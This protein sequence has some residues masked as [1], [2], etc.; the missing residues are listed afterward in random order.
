MRLSGDDAELSVGAALK[1]GHSADLATILNGNSGRPS[2]APHPPTPGLAGCRSCSPAVQ[3][4]FC[5]SRLESAPGGSS[6]P[7]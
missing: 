3:A 6:L 2:P 7:H 5:P 4:C 1:R